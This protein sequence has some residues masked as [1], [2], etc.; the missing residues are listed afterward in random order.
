MGNP[1]K[2]LDL[3]NVVAER[4]RLVFWLQVLKAREA[5]EETI[6]NVE[7]HIVRLARRVDK[8]RTNA[9]IR[10]KPGSKEYTLRPAPKSTVVEYRR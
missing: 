4:N 5:P 7:A 8:G 9:H 3:N 6:Q 2:G 10:K 1:R